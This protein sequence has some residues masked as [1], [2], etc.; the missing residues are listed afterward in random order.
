MFIVK[1]QC[2]IYVVTSPAT[3]LQVL[4]AANYSNNNNNNNNNIPAYMA[5]VCQKTSEGKIWVK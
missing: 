3:L 5:S 1:I 2:V 4:N